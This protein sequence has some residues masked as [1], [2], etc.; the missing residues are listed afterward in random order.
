ME[1]VELFSHPLLTI[2]IHDMHRDNYW[3][4]MY[5]LEQPKSQEAVNIHP[6]DLGL[7]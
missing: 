6:K 2:C 4:F 7:F 3:N 1:W 5:N